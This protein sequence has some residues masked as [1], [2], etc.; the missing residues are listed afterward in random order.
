M[1]KSFAS[2]TPVG[3]WV[4]TSDEVGDAGSLDNRLYVNGEVR[5]DANTSD[6]IVGIAELIELISSVLPIQAGDIIATG[7]PEGVGPIAAG[8]KVTISIQRVGQMTL[9]VEE[10]EAISPRPY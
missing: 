6:L 8:D 2:F 4:V 10:A 9:L 7:T 5:Q 3:P 1:R